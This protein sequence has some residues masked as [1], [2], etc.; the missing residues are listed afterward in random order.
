MPEKFQYDASLKTT[1]LV[2]RDYLLEFVGKWYWYVLVCGVLCVFAYINAKRKPTTYTAT[3]TFM[4]TSDSPSRFSGFMQLAGQLG[5]NTGSAGS[6]LKSEKIV[7]LLSSKYIIYN[8]LLKKIDINGKSDLLFNHYIDLF[9]L[10]ADLERADT[11]LH[12]FRF[13]AT[14][15][16][17]FSFKENKVAS[18]LYKDIFETYLSTNTSKNGIMKAECTTKSE[19]F[20]KEFTAEL[21]KTLSDYYIKKT[22]EQEY[23]AYRLIDKRVDSLYRLLISK[24]NALA[25][26]IDDHRSALRANTLPATVMM[27]QQRLESEAEVLNVMYAEAAKNREVAKMNLVSGT[28]I[29]QIIDY[30]TYPLPKKKPGALIPCFLML[31]ISGGLLTVFFTLRKLVRDAFAA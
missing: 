26:W 23:E 2:I 27:Q 19:Q 12:N 9:D 21:V 3:V 7:E 24:E 30:P 5:I 15:A 25:E 16:D 11:T 18:M 1:L 10:S 6:E 20:S 29:I 4:T 14:D 28:P 22:V 13:T 31:V 8:T 17:K